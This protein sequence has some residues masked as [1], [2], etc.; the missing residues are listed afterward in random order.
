MKK[1]LLHF[2]ILTFVLFSD[3]VMFAQPAED[4]DDGNLEGD[5]EPAAPINSKIIYLAIVG[6]LFALYK[7]KQHKK[8]A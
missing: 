7:Y 8:I 3:F 4:N 1:K 5:D 2:Y 6:V